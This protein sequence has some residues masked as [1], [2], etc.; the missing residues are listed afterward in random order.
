MAEKLIAASDVGQLAIG[1]ENEWAE[2]PP[3]SPALDLLGIQSETLQQRTTTV[4]IDEIEPGAELTDIRRVDLEAGG[5]INAFMRYPAAGNVWDKLTRGFMRKDWSAVATHTATDISFDAAN[6]I[7]R[8]AG[9]WITDGFLVG[10]TVRVA[11][12]TSNDGYFTLTGV[13]ALQLTTEEAGV[14]ESAGASITVDNDGWMKNGVDDVSYLIE[15]KVGGITT[16]FFQQYDGMVLGQYGFTMEPGRVIQPSMTFLGKREQ[17]A[18]SSWDATPT[19]LPS[20]KPIVAGPDLKEVHE[21]GALS[22]LIWTQLSLQVQLSLRAHKGIVGIGHQAEPG[23]GKFMVTGNIRVFVEDKAMYDKY[24]GYTA[25]KVRFR[26]QDADGNV[27]VAYIH[28]FYF[29]DGKILNPGPNNSIFAEYSYKAFRD[30][31][32]GTLSFNRFDA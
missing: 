2:D 28:N 4:D 32:L 14:S 13:T 3:V 30:A 26:L 24:L 5:N 15:K 18:T 10:M 27:V 31:S 22:S 21:G 25:S 20:T 23:R 19:A 7:D 6:H 29:E 9:S 16:P 8:V 1:I 17:T 12:S 11:G